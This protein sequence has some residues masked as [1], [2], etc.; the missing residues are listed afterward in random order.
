MSFREGSLSFLESFAL[1]PCFVVDFALS[2]F[3]V[4]IRACSSSAMC[5]V[6]FLVSRSVIFVA[7]PGL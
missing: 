3:G 5:L 2:L 6:V 4:V 7:C 1:L